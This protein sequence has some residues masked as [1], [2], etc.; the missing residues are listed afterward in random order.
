[1]GGI[2]SRGAFV[3]APN[4]EHEDANGDS[5]WTLEDLVERFFPPKNR[6]GLCTFLTALTV[7]MLVAASIPIV[8]NSIHPA[9]PTHGSEDLHHTH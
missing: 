9:D 4:N 6:P 5:M 1:M 7:L 3:M 8:I 2:G